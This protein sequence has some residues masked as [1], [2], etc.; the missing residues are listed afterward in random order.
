MSVEVLLLI[1]AITVVVVALFLVPTLIQ[2][3][4]TAQRVERLVEETER[5]VFPVM[6]QFR[7]TAENLNRISRDA[8]EG[9][10]HAAP[11]LESMSEIGQFLQRLTGAARGDLGQY[12]G[13]ALGLW[14]GFRAAS[15]VFLKDIHKHKGGD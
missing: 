14:L 3:K 13:N 6:R 15:K 1:I 12:A 11:L 8:Q 9:L 2:M 4:A 5:E 7:D 10:E